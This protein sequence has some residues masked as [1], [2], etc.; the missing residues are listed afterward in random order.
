MTTN[1]TDATSSNQ[2]FRIQ[3]HALNDSNL[4]ATMQQNLSS[5]IHHCV[6]PLVQQA[7][8]INN[9]RSYRYIQ[10]NNQNDNNLNQENNSFSN[11]NTLSLDNSDA[12]NSNHI[13]NNSQE[14][15]NNRNNENLQ[16]IISTP[17]PA[18]PLLERVASLTRSDPPDLIGNNNNNEREENAVAEVF[19]QIPEARRAFDTLFRYIPLICILLAKSAYDHIEALTDFAVLISTF[20][21]SNSVVKNQISKQTQRRVLILFRELIFI[22]FMIFFKFFAINRQNPFI[23]LPLL[24]FITEAP[25]LSQLLYWVAATDFLLK[26]ITV[27]IKIFIITL[28]PNVIKYKGRVS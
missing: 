23:C 18:R 24:T 2:D 5:L 13:E 28:P 21:H 17:S 7:Q 16:R 22:A 8:S 20:I 9:I 15:S 3:I 1:S 27:S 10:F 25:T 6:R 14:E 4:S 26:L 11:S 19:A 12:I